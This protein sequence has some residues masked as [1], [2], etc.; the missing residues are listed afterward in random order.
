MS[1]PRIAI[2]SLI[3][4]LTLGL[5]ACGNDSS[6]PTSPTP[7]RPPTPVSGPDLVVTELSASDS[8]L[9]PYTPFTLRVAVRNDGDRAAAATT[10]RYYQSTDATI[11][12]ADT[13]VG[14][15]AV[16]G[17]AAAGSS[18]ESVELSAPSIPGT[19]YYGACVDAVA[20]ESDT[21]NNCSRSVQVEV[22]EPTDLEVTEFS[23]SDTN[24]IAGSMLTLSATVRNNSDSAIVDVLLRYSFS[25]AGYGLQTPATTRLAVLAASESIDDSVVVR[26]PSPG[27]YEFSA[28]VVDHSPSTTDHS[29]K[30]I[31]VTVTEPEPDPDPDPQPSCCPDLVVTKFSVSDTNPIAGSTLTLSATVQNIGTG[32]SGG[33]FLE[34]SV[35]AGGGQ[36]AASTLLAGLAASESI[37]DSVVV[38]VPSPGTY[39]Y[40]AC[41][42]ESTASGGTE[43]CSRDIVVTVEQQ[44]PD[45]P[46]IDP[47]FDDAFWQEFVFDQKDEPFTLDH[48]VI[49]V[50]NT[51][52]PNVY[53]YMGTGHQVIPGEHRDIIREA[54]PSAAEQLTGQRYS[55]RIESGTEHLDER[56]G[57]ITVRYFTD[58]DQHGSCGFAR[59]GTDPNTI[60]LNHDCIKR[61]GPDAI[62]YLR[63]VFVHEFGHAMGFK[64]VL[65]PNAVMAAL[66]N[67]SDTFTA[68]EQFHAQLAYKI[69]RGARY[70]GWPFSAECE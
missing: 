15:A 58:A 57:W 64:H 43:N 54:I 48:Q 59:V 8:N 28:Y 22:S 44:T 1:L 2:L 41:V 3:G 9:A 47:R 40:T 52:R 53:I 45:D 38:R 55:G 65:A 63:H 32:A 23:V 20:D 16:A 34:Y 70:C 46:S 60:F 4:S 21:T 30:R 37:D 62:A 67:L 29:S 33:V 5:A 36:R 14:T 27:T 7:L 24:P 6:T 25:R 56:L 69:G 13:V 26:V 42:R 10:L 35:T 50:L 51:T 18:S 39:E 49:Q 19:Y 17:L 61:R 66:G 12:S 11:T 68:R 31:T